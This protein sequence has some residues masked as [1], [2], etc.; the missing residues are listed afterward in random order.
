MITIKITNVEDVVEKQKGWFIA[1]VV[2]A[3]VDLE[4]RVEDRVI[5]QLRESLANQGV[6][7]VIERRAG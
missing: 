3:F 1:N 7:A 5:E 6:E 2:G 4:A